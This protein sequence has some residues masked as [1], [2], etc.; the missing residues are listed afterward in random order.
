MAI[1]YQ[2]NDPH[3]KVLKRTDDSTTPDTITYV[4]AVVG[5]P[6]YSHN[7]VDEQVVGQPACG[8]EHNACHRTSGREAC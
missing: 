4:P 7:S 6:D 5:W 3:Q 1:S 8:P 2:W